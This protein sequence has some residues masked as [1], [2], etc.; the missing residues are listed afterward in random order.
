[1]PG[2]RGFRLFS[3]LPFKILADFGFFNSF[4]ALY[5]PHFMDF[6]RI[7]SKDFKREPVSVTS[8]SAIIES[9]NLIAA[10]EG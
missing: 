8:A 3:T 1:M 6:Q 9:V 2:K 5:F 10:V 7:S 4:Q